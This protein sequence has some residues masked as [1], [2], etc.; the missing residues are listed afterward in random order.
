[1]I[2]LMLRRLASDT[3]AQEFGYQEA[4]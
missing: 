4:A 2:H 1:M 3:P